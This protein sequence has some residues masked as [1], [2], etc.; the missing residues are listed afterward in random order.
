M[1]KLTLFHALCEVADALQ[2]E[3]CRLHFSPLQIALRAIVER[4]DVLIDQVLEEGVHEEEP[5]A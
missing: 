3:Y 5:H 2:A 1:T 4:V